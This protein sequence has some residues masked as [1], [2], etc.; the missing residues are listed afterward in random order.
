MHRERH[1]WYDVYAKQN[2]ADRGVKWQFIAPASPHHGGLWEA[3]VKS[4]KRHL[5]RVVGEQKL[6]FQQ[7]NTLLIRI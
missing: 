2:I 4:A 3:A 6:R 1:Q 7:L 5:L